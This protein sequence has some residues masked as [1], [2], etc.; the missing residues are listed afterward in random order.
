MMEKKYNEL[1]TTILTLLRH[2][3]L[4]EDEMTKDITA[5]RLTPNSATLEKKDT[6]QKS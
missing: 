6:E 3:R 4:S 2:L 5:L 1:K